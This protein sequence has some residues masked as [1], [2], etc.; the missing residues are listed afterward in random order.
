MCFPREGKLEDTTNHHTDV[1]GLRWKIPQTKR[2][3]S[4][5]HRLGNFWWLGETDG[6]LLSEGFSCFFHLFECDRNLCPT[7]TIM[8]ASPRKHKWSSDK[9]AALKITKRRMHKS[10]KTIAEWKLQ[11]P[12][13]VRYPTFWPLLDFFFFFFFLCKFLPLN[14]F[15]GWKKLY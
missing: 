11:L 3:Y 9:T 5:K 2:M 13:T 14:C 12:F 8:R 7:K 10:R 4:Y 15:Q 1:C 6:K